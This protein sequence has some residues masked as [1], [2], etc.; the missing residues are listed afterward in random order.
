LFNEMIDRSRWKLASDV[1]AARRHA[2]EDLRGLIEG[3][4]STAVNTAA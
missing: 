2:D 3:F 1:S 4:E